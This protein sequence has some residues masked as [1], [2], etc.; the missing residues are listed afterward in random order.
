MSMVTQENSASSSIAFHVV[1]VAAG[2]GA[3][4][5]SDVPKQFLSLAGEAILRR[6]VKAFLNCPGCMSVCVVH[7]S[8]DL[9]R[10]EAALSGLSVDRFIE[11]GAT[12][13]DSVYNGLKS[14]SVAADE[15]V[16]IHDAARPMV[17]EHDILNLVTTVHA[18]K[19]A[20]LA[21]PVSDTLVYSDHERVS[22]DH[23]YALQTPQGFEYGLIMKAHDAAK[24][25][26]EYTDDTA[27]VLELGHGVEYIQGSKTNFKIT[28]QDDLNMAEQLLQAQYNDIRTG[29]GFDVHA[30]DMDASG[31]V[32][33]CGVDVA[34]DY[35]LKG[36]S[37]ADVGLHAIT[38]AIL[39]AIGKGDI[40][41]HFPPSDDTYKDMDSAIFLEKAMGILTDAD[42]VL[43]NIDITIICERPKVG[44]HAAE[45]RTRIA[46]ITNLDESRINVKATTSEKL[47]FTGRGEG[48]AAQ[49]IATIGVRV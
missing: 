43:K 41:Q 28:T 29:I 47:G 49:A 34:H 11:G 35:A 27:L 10:V 31:P 7:G 25:E 44:P 26:A 2:S 38:D 19:A 12:R 16:F 21:V 39:G 6:S 4:M 5:K 24:P 15:I 13:K 45:M 8:D 17:Q 36:H 1:I 48:I 3:R 42:A 32:R 46:G 33:L 18:H 9:E 40:G 22:R 30:F 20:S 23:L 37:D 14:M